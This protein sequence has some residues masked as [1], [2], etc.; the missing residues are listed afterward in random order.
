MALGDDG[1]IAR[2]ATRMEYLI[3]DVK[4]LK[5]QVGALTN[6]LNT[7]QSEMM[8][9]ETNSMSVGQIAWLMLT[10]FGIS[11]AIVLAIYLGGRAG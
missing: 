2:L 7:V 8:R 6:T 1:E 3:E 9:R 11:A 4:S 10:F 5:T